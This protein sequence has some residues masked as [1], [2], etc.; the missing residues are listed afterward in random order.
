M[1]PGEPEC[2][3]YCCR[4]WTD[5][6]LLHY[7]DLWAGVVGS[8][9]FYSFLQLGTVSLRCYVS[10]MSFP[11]EF[12]RVVCHPQNRGA[13]WAYRG[14]PRPFATPACDAWSS[15]SFGWLAVTFIRLL[16]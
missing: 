12:L 11:Y 6:C 14:N 10:G 13:V 8:R 9:M 3:S 2:R 15:M 16:C 7:R 4:V 1:L 5:F